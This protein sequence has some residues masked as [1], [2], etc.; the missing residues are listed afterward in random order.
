MIKAS[1]I[2]AL[3]VN[4]LVASVLVL[5]H[6]ASP[7]SASQNG[8]RW[9][10]DARKGR[11]LFAAYCAACHQANGEG[12]SGLFPPLKGSAV[13]NRDD[14]TKHIRVVLDG[15]QGGRVSGVVYASAMPAFGETLSDTEIAEIVDYERSSWGNRGSFVS[16]DRV[17]L[18]RLQSA[19]PASDRGGY[20]AAK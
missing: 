2:A 13:V 6:D 7:G 9:A 20:R 11:E 3:T 8:P 4:M 17:A 12:V 15:L 19:P 10:Y 14:A 16:A 1:H 5:A 18:E